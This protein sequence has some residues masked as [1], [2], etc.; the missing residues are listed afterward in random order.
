MWSWSAKSVLWGAKCMQKIVLWGQIVDL[1]GVPEGRGGGG[2]TY[3]VFGAKYT[4]LRAKCG[5]T[6]TFSVPSV[7]APRYVCFICSQDVSNIVVINVSE[8]G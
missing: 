8:Y 6:L 4:L 1:G 7:A 3:L 2:G 5:F